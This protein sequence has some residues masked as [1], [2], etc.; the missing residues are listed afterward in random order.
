MVEARRSSDAAYRVP[1]MKN[2]NGIAVNAVTN[3]DPVAW[4]RTTRTS[5]TARSASR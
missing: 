4:N 3:Q 2:I 5:A 1:A